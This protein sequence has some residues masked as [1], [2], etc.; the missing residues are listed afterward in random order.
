VKSTVWSL[1]ACLALL[2]LAGCVRYEET[3]QLDKSGKG[4]LTI[5][6][7]RPARG[8]AQALANFDGLF[9]RE[10]MSKDLPAGVS[11]DYTPIASEERAGVRATY[12]FD[13]VARLASWAAATNLPINQLSVAFHGNTFE[14]TRRFGPFDEAAMQAANEYAAEAVIIFR[15]TGPG[16]LQVNN[17]TR[18]E[19]DTAVWEI[20][21][22]VLISRNT[23][24]LRAQYSWG[25]PGWLYGAVAALVVIAVAAIVRFRRRR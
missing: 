10:N 13:D 18:V 6:M 3:L 20:K 8:P 22:P 25:V 24:A 19:G 17:A 1:L 5:V 16:R 7:E 21:A 15:L 4:S 14:Y 2:T 9:S 11:L 12:H 23:P